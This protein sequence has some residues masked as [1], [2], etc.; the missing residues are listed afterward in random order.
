M[1]YSLTMCLLKLGASL[2]LV[3]IV[4]TT[5]VRQVAFAQ[6]PCGGPDVSFSITGSAAM[7]VMSLGTFLPSNA[8]TVVGAASATMPAEGSAPGW[9]FFHF[10]ITIP[11]GRGIIAGWRL[12]AASSGLLSPDAPTSPDIDLHLD[13]I[14]PGTFIGSSCGTTTPSA[15]PVDLG[16]GGTTSAATYVTTVVTGTSAFYCAIPFVTNGSYLIPT[17]AAAGTYAGTIT[18]TLQNT[19]S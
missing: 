5:L 19:S 6:P 12:Q 17:D 2:L 10:A 9:N 7:C 14:T 4:G 15:T 3:G 13:S 8:L 11:D 18:L 1:R 16:P